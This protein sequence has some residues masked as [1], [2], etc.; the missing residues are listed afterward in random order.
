MTG[1]LALVKRERD[2][3]L[4]LHTPLCCTPLVLDKGDAHSLQQISL[5]KIALITITGDTLHE[6]LIRFLVVPQLP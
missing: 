2:C 1:G 6:V 5:I 4:V 3:V